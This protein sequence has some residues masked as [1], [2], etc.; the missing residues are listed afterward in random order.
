MQERSAVAD[1]LLPARNHGVVLS[2]TAAGDMGHL[3]GR[4]VQQLDR[5]GRIL[6]RH[7]EPGRGPGDMGAGS[8]ARREQSASPRTRFAALERKAAHSRAQHSQSST[9]RR[10]Y[11]DTGAFSADDAMTYNLEAY[12]RKGPYLVGFEYLGT[13]VE[14]A[15]SG[16]PFFSGYNITGSWAVTGEMRAYRKRS[17]TFDPLPVSRP[18]NQGGWGALETAIR[19]SRL[20]LT[21]GKVDGGEMDILSLGLNWWLTR[22]AQFGV[23]Y[24]YIFL[25]RFDIQGDSSGLNTRITLVLD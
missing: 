4:G 24:R 18:V 17:G 2:G 5:F 25:D 8:L 3:G 9:T 21:D 13:D 14:S 15:D 11:V 6:Q 23:N 10:C 12:W 20:D 1:A 7:F 19:Y 22:R 16:D